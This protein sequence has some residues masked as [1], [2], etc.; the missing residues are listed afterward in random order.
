MILLPHSGRPQEAPSKG[1]DNRRGFDLPLCDVPSI[2]EAG[3]KELWLFESAAGGR[4]PQRPP[5]SRSTGQPQGPRHMADFF[6]FVFFFAKENEHKSLIMPSGFIM[7]PIINQVW[8]NRYFSHRIG[9]TYP[10]PPL[11]VEVLDKK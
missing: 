2:A 1:A 4:V 9:R 3:E 5:D 8:L 11:E 7:A 6:W 10:G